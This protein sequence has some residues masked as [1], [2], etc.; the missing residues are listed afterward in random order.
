MGKINLVGDWIGLCRINGDKLVPLPKFQRTKNSNVGARSS[1]FSYSGFFNQVNKRFGASIKNRQFQIVEL[2]DGV[3]DPQAHECGKQMLG[4]RNQHAL[5]HQAGRVANPS[6]VL[7]NRL[8]FETI[9]VYSSKGDAGL[10][11]H[12]H[13]AAMWNKPVRQFYILYSIF[14]LV[15]SV[16]WYLPL[17]TR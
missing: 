11:S 9:Q 2:D 1:L 13:A 10:L 6:D 14:S 8:N 7:P 16:C 5:F 15:N 4:G 17:P 12:L 3:V